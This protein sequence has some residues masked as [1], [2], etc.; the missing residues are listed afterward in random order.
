MPIEDSDDLKIKSEIDEIAHKIDVILTKIE[1]LTFTNGS[2]END[3][4]ES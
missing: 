3:S 1:G 2:P 4:D